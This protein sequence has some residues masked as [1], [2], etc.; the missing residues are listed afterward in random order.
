MHNKSVKDSTIDGYK[1]ANR[2][3]K[4]YFLKS[5]LDY[6]H[7]LHIKNSLVIHGFLFLF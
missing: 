4:K 6:L 3:D 7:S 1:L 5:A 2:I